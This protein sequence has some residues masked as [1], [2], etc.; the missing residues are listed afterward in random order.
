MPKLA[1]QG[2]VGDGAEHRSLRVGE[3]YRKSGAG[4]LLVQAF[5]LGARDRQK[6]AQALLQFLDGLG[7][8][9]VVSARGRGFDSV[10]PQAPMPGPGDQ[11]LDAGG[12]KPAFDHL[13][14]V[15]RMARHQSFLLQALPL[16]L[17]VIRGSHTA[18]PTPR[19][20]S[21]L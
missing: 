9:Y 19:M 15:G 2:R 10:F 20:G 6:L 8:E 5:H 16:E 21:L 12:L 17:S 11:G 3:D 14:D 13:D 4:N 1:L 7:I 18:H